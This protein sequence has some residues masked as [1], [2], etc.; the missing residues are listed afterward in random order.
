[1]NQNPLL[2]KIFLVIFVFL[3]AILALNSC[4][5]DD[6]EEDSGN[7]KIR[8]Q[9]FHTV[10]GQD[11]EFNNLKYFNE[12]GNHYM[13]TDFQYFISDVILYKA[14]GSQQLIND[15]QDIW[16]VDNLIPSSLNW[17]VYDPIPSGDYDSLSFIF[18]I[19]R[20]KN[21]TGLFV[22]PP[23]VN[24]FWPDI[25]GGGYHYFKLNGK[26]ID[27]TGME[28]P[29]NFHT[30]IGREITATDTIWHHS[31]FRVVLPES[32]F[33][34]SADQTT[35]IGIQMQIESWFKTPHQWN[36]DS[37]GGAIMVDWQAMQLGMENGYDVFKRK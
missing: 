7:G 32:S 11:V 6:G 24:M 37:I 21:V 28:V 23:E 35:S 16:Y 36:W 12:A 29:F 15:W 33:T 1:M 3:P 14:D 5:R 22:N 26:W 17:E 19:S 9:F 8:L 2:L 10:D 25:L 34:V 27:T 4:K 18:G 13:I 20:E 30:G 31:A